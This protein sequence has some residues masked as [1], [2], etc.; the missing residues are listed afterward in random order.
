MQVISAFRGVNN[1][2][3]CPLVLCLLL[4]STEV[5]AEVYKWVDSNGKV[6]YGSS[7]PPKYVES[8]EAVETDLVNTVAPEPEI[9][10]QN[11]RE[12]QKLRV[13]DS[14]EQR[15]KAERESAKKS[16][17]GLSNQENKPTR[18]QC[19]DQFVTVKQKT[20]CFKRVEEN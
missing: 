5:L 18:E 6:H 12:V 4:G 11:K 15:L 10:A 17:S 9:R 14:Q 8:A 3:I 19:R 7:I 20:E 2:L 1:A 13:Q 16:K